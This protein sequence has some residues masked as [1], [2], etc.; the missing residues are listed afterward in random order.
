MRVARARA[1]GRGCLCKRGED[2]VWHKWAHGYCSISSVNAQATLVL[3]IDPESRFSNRWDAQE[4]LE[5][6]LPIILPA[7]CGPLSD[8]CRDGSASSRA[9]GYELLREL[10][11][12]RRTFEACIYGEAHVLSDAVAVLREMDAGLERAQVSPP[13]LKPHT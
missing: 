13:T 2:A 11:R 12:C 9:S 8:V 3:L 7:G 5:L 1:H 10:S 4:E 6:F